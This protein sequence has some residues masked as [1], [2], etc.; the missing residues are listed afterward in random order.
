MVKELS[1]KGP[2][3]ATPPAAHPYSTLDPLPVPEAVE[4]DTDSAWGL[5]QDSIACQDTPTE[6]AFENTVPAKLPPAATTTPPKR[7]P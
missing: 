6:T 2:A 5:W 7:R 3:V 4:S 1:T